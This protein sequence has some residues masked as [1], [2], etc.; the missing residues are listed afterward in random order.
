MQTGMLTMLERLRW[1]G[2]GLVAGLV[3]GLFLGWLFH[4]FVS[5]LFRLLIIAIILSPFIVALVFWL[6]VSN[7]NRAER[8]GSAIQEAEWRDINSRSQ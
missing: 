8:S 2:Y 5:T 7:R 6:K 1:A 4:G 3:V